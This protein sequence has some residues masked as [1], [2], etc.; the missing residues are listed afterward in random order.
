MSPDSI[1]PE[2]R[3]ED[4]L[5]DYTPLLGSGSSRDDAHPQEE[6]SL[7]STLLIKIYVIV[8]CLNLGVQILGPSQTQIF[9]SIYC[10]QWYEQH[11]ADGLPGDGNIPESYCKIPYVQT[12]V[13]TLRGWLEFFNAA[14][15]LL[16]SIPF[17][18][19]SDRIGRRILL[20]SGLVVFCMN[21]AWTAFISWFGGQ[22]P[23]EAVWFGA[24]LYFLSGGTIVL[25]ML[26]VV[27]LPT[28]REIW[29][30]S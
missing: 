9:E 10:S 24:S 22:I 16:L 23:L 18:I 13:S 12:K 1:P 21:Q 3:S 4:D 26:Y 2:N 28:R 6:P 8:F 7:H 17:G 14:P 29:I 20:L 27:C 5:T 15:A 25:E 11:P 30:L 19:L